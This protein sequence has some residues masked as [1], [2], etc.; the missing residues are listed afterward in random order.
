MTAFAQRIEVTGPWITQRELDYVADAARTN[1]FGRANDYIRR[2]ERAFAEHTGRKH[3]V[4][5]SSCSSAIL[6]ALKSLGVGPGDEVIIPELTWIA[7]AAPV[8]HAG[9]TP[10]F[11]D[12]DRV[13]WCLDPA[14][15]ERCI[16]ARTR[17]VIP[18]DLYGTFPPM[19]KIETL[20]KA[21]GLAV[22]ED[23]AQ[24][25]GAVYHGRPAG[26]FGATSVFSFH[27][28]KTLTTGEGGMFVTDDDALYHRAVFL[29]DQG[30]RPEDRSLYNRE[31]GYK[32]KMSSMQ[33]AMGL[34]QLERLPE[35]VAAKRQHADWYRVRLERL[36]GITFNQEA[37]GVLHTH[38][39]NN[40]V[41]EAARQWPKEKV[42]DYFLANNVVCR[43]LFYPLSS[44]PAFAKFPGIGEC[45]GRNPVSHAV[46]PYGVNLPSGFH[47]TEETVDG[48]CRLLARLLG[49]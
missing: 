16:T 22:I 34:A 24:A 23:A 7:T 30:R 29:A 33:A 19:E 39:M 36:A 20:A 32:M 21:R 8:V 14:S 26:N 3:A 10:V 4:A 28:S 17:A 44:L 48:V 5:T 49:Q 12:V 43:P 9:A 15:F 31:I 27:G 47:L 2:F 18:V 35:L 25:A 42:I 40:V 46:G 1:W 41:I 6:L 45:A 13:N 11:A 38:W 37:P